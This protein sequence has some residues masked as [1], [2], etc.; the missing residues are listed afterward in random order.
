M[1]YRF[2]SR[3]KMQRPRLRQLRSCIGHPTSGQCAAESGPEIDF[4]EIQDQEGYDDL[5]EVKGVGL[6][7][8]SYA[9]NALLLA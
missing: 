6:E 2:I 7:S 4:V 9:F 5:E 8:V 1:Q 3:C